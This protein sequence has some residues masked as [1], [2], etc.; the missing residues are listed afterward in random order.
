MTR[1]D[2]FWDDGPEYEKPEIDAE[3]RKLIS[4]YERETEIIKAQAEM[5]AEILKGM[6]Q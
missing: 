6:R 4:D 5:L 3:A 2:V 1:K